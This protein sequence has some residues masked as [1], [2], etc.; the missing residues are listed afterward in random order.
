MIAVIYTHNL[1]GLRIVQS[2]CVSFSSK[3][4]IIN[5]GRPS[6]QR[7]FALSRCYLLRYSL[8]L[9]RKTL[10][11]PHR[12]YD[13]M[14]QSLILLLLSALP[15]IV[16]LYCLLLLQLE[17]GF[18]RRYLWNSFSRCNNPYPGSS[19]SAYYRFFL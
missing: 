15:Y 4:I 11:F 17:E 1:I 9:Y 13:L 16:N 5:F 10:L 7:S 8:F 12:Y 6:A 2:I 19:Y 18:S 3:P 14:R